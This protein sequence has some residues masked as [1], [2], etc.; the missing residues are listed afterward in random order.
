VPHVGQG[1]IGLLK[2]DFFVIPFRSRELG[3][4]DSQYLSWI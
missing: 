3:V 1:F 2:R 4:S